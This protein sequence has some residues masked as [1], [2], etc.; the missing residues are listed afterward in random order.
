[1]PAFL[2]TDPQVPVSGLRQ[3]LGRKLSLL[4]LDFLQAQ[5]VGRLFHG[6]ALQVLDPEAD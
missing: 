6:E 2:P 5:N 3:R 1:M 4:A